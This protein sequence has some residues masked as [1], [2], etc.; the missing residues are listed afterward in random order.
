MH[1]HRIGTLR[2]CE[3]P[4]GFNALPEAPDIVMQDTADH[5]RRLR[6]AA[7]TALIRHDPSTPTSTTVSI[8]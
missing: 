7:S 2:M 8:P 1:D 5:R 6:R 4:A 3:R